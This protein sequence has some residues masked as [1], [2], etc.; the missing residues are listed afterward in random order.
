MRQINVFCSKL[1]PWKSCY[2]LLTFNDVLCARKAQCYVWQWENFYY[3]CVSLISTTDSSDNYL[4]FREMH[5]DAKYIDDRT[6]RSFKPTQFTTPRTGNLTIAPALPACVLKQRCTRTYTENY[7]RVH[8]HAYIQYIQ[9]ERQTDR[10][11]ETYT[12]TNH[13]R[14]GMRAR[15]CS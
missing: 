9:T 12:Q 7:T 4:P 5:S 8:V 13:W 3:T 1:F 10:Q 14:T 11:T 15:W 2:L 6:W